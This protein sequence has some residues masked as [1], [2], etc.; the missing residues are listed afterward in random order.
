MKESSIEITLTVQLVG[1]VAKSFNLVY[2]N[3]SCIF[4]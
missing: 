2:R 3:I 4:Y 1:R